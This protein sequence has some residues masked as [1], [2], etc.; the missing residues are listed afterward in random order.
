MIFIEFDGNDG[1]H[2]YEGEDGDEYVSGLSVS[3]KD[4]VVHKRH[5]NSFK[6]SRLAEV[7]AGC[8][9]DS[10]LIV[11][12]V[13]QLCVMATYFGAFDCGITPFMMKGGIIG[14]DEE[15]ELHCEAVVKLFDREDVSDNLANVSLPVPPEIK[16][17]AD[18]GY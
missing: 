10:I 2:I 5:M 13:A 16:R 8:G 4:I 15:K 17:R 1:F 14:T 9:C 3:P 6:D 12:M 11:G 7:V 18:S